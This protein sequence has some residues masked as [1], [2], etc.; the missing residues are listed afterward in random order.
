MFYTMLESLLHIGSWNATNW[1]LFALVV[2]LV[3]GLVAMKLSSV[4]RLF[5]LIPVMLEV[6][7]LTPAFACTR[8]AMFERAPGTQEACSNQAYSNY[9]D[10]NFGLNHWYVVVAYAGLALFMIWPFI[11]GRYK[12]SKATM[13]AAFEAD[14]A[15]AE[16]SKR[17]DSI[18][19]IGGI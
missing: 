8:S 1:G 12:S 5:L 2:V 9:L 3:G 4:V 18:K 14:T 6:Y 19:R 7:F 15:A 10:L 17:I 11:A 13:A 16:G